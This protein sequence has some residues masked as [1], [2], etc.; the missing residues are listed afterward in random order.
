MG[1]RERQ[2]NSKKSGEI[3][4]IGMACIFPKSRNLK[5]F[6]QNIVSKVDAIT[7]VDADRWDQEIFYDDNNKSGKIYCKKSGFIDNL[8]E[9]DPLNFGIMPFAVSGAE[10]DQFLT[11]KVAYEA[12]MDAGYTDKKIGREGIKVIIGRS[13]YLGRGSASISQ[14]T[15]AIE[16]KIEIFKKLYPEYTEEDIKLIKEALL[17]NLPDLSSDNAPSMIPNMLTG[18]ISNKFDFMGANYT[19]DADCASVF[20]AA[21][22]GIRDLITRN[23]DVVIVGGIYILDIPSLSIFSKTGVLSPSCAIRPFDDK[24]DGVIPGEGIGALILKR[25]E[26]AEQD[27]D[28]IYAVIKGI[29]SFS[30]H[31]EL[32]EI[33]TESVEEKISAMSQAYEMADIDSDSI[34]FI[35]AHGTA[36]PELDIAELKALAHFYNESNGNEIPS[37][38]MGSVKSMIGNTMSAAGAAS[39]IKAILALYHKVIPPSINCDKPN[40]KFDWEKSGIYVNTENRPWI[41]GKNMPRR[42]MVNAFSFSGVNASIILEEYNSKDKGTTKNFCHEWDSEVLILQGESRRSLIQELRQLQ[43]YLVKDTQAPLRDISYSLNSNLNDKSHKLSIVATSKDDLYEKIKYSLAYLSEPGNR[44]NMGINGVF[45]SENPLK[46]KIA[47]LFP[48]ENSQYLNMISDLCIHFPEIRGIF[49]DLDRVFI[50]KNAQ[51]LPS[52]VVFPHSNF[53]EVEY[54]I[55]ESRLNNFDGAVQAVLVANGAIDMLLDSLGINPNMVVGYSMGDISAAIAAG[56]IQ[57][58]DNLAQTIDNLYSYYIKQDI[59]NSSNLRQLHFTTP[60]VPVYSCATAKPYPDDPKAFQELIIK[61]WR[62][63]VRFHDTI[64]SIYEE[65]AR[66]FVEVGIQGN[67]TKLVEETLRGKEYLAIAS[68]LQHNS[69]IYQLNTLIGALVVNGVSANL[70]RLY[71]M[72]SANLISLK[73]EEN[74]DLT[75]KS[76]NS[77]MKLKLGF[78]A[79]VLDENPVADREISDPIEHETESIRTQEPSK[80]PSEQ[81]AYADPEADTAPFIPDNSEI[82]MGD[83][84]SFILSQHMETMEKFLDVEEKIM[85]AY[86]NSEDFESIDIVEQN[87]AEFIPESTILD[88]KSGDTDVYYNLPFIGNV[89]YI[90]PGQKVEVIRELSIDEDIFLRDHTFGGKI[91]VDETLLPLSIVPMTVGI[92]MMSEVAVLLCPGKILVAVENLRANK[93]IMVEEHKATKLRFVAQ[94][95]ELSSSSRSEV[96]VQILDSEQINMA[97][98]PKPSPVMEAVIIFEDTYPEVPTTGIIQIQ[99]TVPCSKNAKQMYEEYIMFHGPGFQ[100]V[101]SLDGIN[102]K[103]IDANLKALDN[104]SLFR[105]IKNPRLVLD[106]VL[107]DAV[108]QVLG[109]WAFEKLEEG[110]NIFPIRIKTLHV[111]RPNIAKDEYAKCRIQIQRLNSRRI[112]MNADIIDPDGRLWMRILG[113]EDWRFY[114]PENIFNFWRFPDKA[115][116]TADC[117]KLFGISHVYDKYRIDKYSACQIFLVDMLSK[118]L[119]RG[120]WILTWAYQIL[121]HQERQVFQNLRDQEDIRDEWLM[122]TGVAKDAIRMYINKRYG[123]ELYPADIEISYDQDGYPLVDGYWAEDIKSIPNVSLSTYGEVAVAM[124]DESEFIGVDIEEIREQ[125]DGSDRVWTKEE[126]T[127]LSKFASKSQKLELAARFTCAKKSL[128]KAL[129]RE[130]EEYYQD[131]SVTLYELDQN[132]PDSQMGIVKVAL[133]GM[134]ARDFPEHAQKEITIYTSRYKNYI[135]AISKM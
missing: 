90:S 34:Q 71:E 55:A 40:V 121:S 115:F 3:A 36:I 22:I 130:Y 12:L 50:E 83:E 73:A 16:Q 9:F 128:S 29:G 64:L 17:E 24:A 26:D 114:N 87:A 2:V 105:S 108:G 66:I 11:L 78:P 98:S 102:D 30:S 88:S 97:K 21:E 89:E 112:L 110:F 41:H 84:Q 48:G 80:S 72:R 54:K 120:I 103:G 111:Y 15:I 79:M 133:S 7:E 125:E 62:K 96:V 61:Q 134:F 51:I 38:A 25:L 113:W 49:D 67:L 59:P 116:I 28:R 126:Q 95:Q 100:A 123:L 4:V 58:Q 82:V 124:A 76:S 91:S 75:G 8:T 23:C 56:A 27:K 92:E 18:R 20:V 37:V 109:Y 129:R 118:D 127:I 5:K 119:N 101:A 52:Q 33:N 85:K 86:L 70:N 74:T 132:F 10:P 104:S 57:I 63:P 19:V 68:N 31:V 69:A 1:S 65:G 14:H 45:F 93:W 13:N 77:I 32:S 6:W 131:I 47:F 99:D 135:I 46:G 42:A 117:Y 60:S 35:E 44:G 43:E 107:L 122:K 94:T 81:P 53:S 39:L 106:P